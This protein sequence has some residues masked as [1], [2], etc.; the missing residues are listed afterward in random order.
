MVDYGQI[1]NY[2]FLLKNLEFL[3]LESVPLAEV[4][5]SRHDTYVIGEMFQLLEFNYNKIFK[6]H[7]TFRLI[8]IDLSWATIHAAL[9]HLNSQTLL[10]YVNNVYQISKATDLKEYN[11]LL[12][13]Y[14]CSWLASCCIQTFS[15]FTKALRA[16]KVFCPKDKEEFHF[17][18][19]CF[20]L[21]LNTVD[22]NATIAIF[23]QICILFMS[24]II[25]SQVIAARKFL[26]DCLAERPADIQ[27]VKEIIRK[28]FLVNLD[29]DGF[30]LDTYEIENS[31]S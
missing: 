1:L 31:S 30:E 5:S 19:C 4:S 7:L 20:S 24:E 21:L 8:V 25:T 27:Q 17:A 29:E 13:Q 11:L 6:K 10:E 22:L 2:A 26:E 15:R 12:K 16:S 3:D 28:I 14:D 23:N 18:V 9:K